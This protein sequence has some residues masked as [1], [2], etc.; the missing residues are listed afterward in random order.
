MPSQSPSYGK[1]VN[2]IRALWFVH[3][4]LHCDVFALSITF[5]RNKSM[6]DFVSVRTQRANWH[7]QE[8]S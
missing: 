4:E 3:T 5:S 7:Q 2:S 1:N 6:R 8:G